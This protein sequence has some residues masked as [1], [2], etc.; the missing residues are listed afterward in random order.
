MKKLQIIVKKKSNQTIEDIIFEISSISGIDLK[1]KANWFDLDE[2]SF[3]MW[4]NVIWDLDRIRISKL[5]LKL[6][7]TLDVSITDMPS[8]WWNRNSDKAF[9]FMGLTSVVGLIIGTLSWL[10]HSSQI[11]YSATIII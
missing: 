1:E 5:K 7:E 9:L 11:I 3:W 10:T 2:D 8:T 4:Q 6:M